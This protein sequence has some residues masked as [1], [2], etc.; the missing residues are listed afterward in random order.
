MM[1][2]NHNSTFTYMKNVCKKGLTL[3][4]KWIMPQKIV[5][6]RVTVPF[7]SKQLLAEAPYPYYH[8][9]EKRGY[10]WREGVRKHFAV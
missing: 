7:T 4:L 1:L 9:F 5:Y 6:D 8:R 10:M 2:M 3:Y